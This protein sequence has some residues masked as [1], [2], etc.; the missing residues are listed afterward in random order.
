M[1]T[2][3]DDGRLTYRVQVRRDGS[4]YFDKIPAERVR[5]DMVDRRVGRS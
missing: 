3:H 1:R 4:M 2:T 5:L